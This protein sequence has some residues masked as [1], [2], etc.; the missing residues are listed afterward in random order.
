MSKTVNRLSGITGS[1]F[2][3]PPRA[4]LSWRRMSWRTLSSCKGGSRTLM[5]S[6][7]LMMVGCTTTT[8]SVNE[9]PR[10]PNIRQTAPATQQ[11]NSNTRR[12][13]RQQSNQPVAL[14]ELEQA[15]VER[16]IVRGQTRSYQILNWFGQPHSVTQSGDSVFWNYTHRVQDSRRGLAGLKSL[17]VVLNNANLVVDFEFQSNLYSTQTDSNN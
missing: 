16:L 11:T 17:N 5:L 13:A 6:L 4:V 10:D 9:S 7:M 3:R 14:K 15:D 1:L 12:P 8:R 2:N